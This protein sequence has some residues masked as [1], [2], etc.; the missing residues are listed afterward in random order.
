MARVSV[1]VEQIANKVKELFLQHIDNNDVKI[2]TGDNLTNFEVTRSLAAYAVYWKNG[3]SIAD[4]SGA[5]TD[6][7]GDNGIDAIYYNQNT[8]RLTI[9]QS[10]FIKDGNSEPEASEIR[11]FREGIFD[12]IEG[13]INSFNDKVKSK[14]EIINKIKEFGTKVDV[15]LVH[16]SRE[17]LADPSNEIIR[18]MMLDLN[19][20]DDEDGVFTFH[21]LH[22]KRIITSLTQALGGNEIKLEFLLKDYG[23]IKEPLLS[24]YGK[25][26]GSKLK[27]WWDLHSDRLFRDNIRNSLGNTSV[28][29]IVEKTI[30]DR[31]DYFWFFN[32]GITVIADLIDK[33]IENGNN[34]DFG[35]FKAENASIVNGAQTYSTIGKC[36]VKGVNIDK[37][38]VPFRVIQ[39][40][41]DVKELK[42]DIT[43]YN[44]TQ[45]TILPKDFLSQNDVQISLQEKLSLSGYKYVIKRDSTNINGENSFDF[46]EVTESLISTSNNPGSAA[47][48]RKEIG[49]F[50]NTESNLYKSV[51][52]NTIN[53]YRVINSVK[54]NRILKQNLSKV[55]ADLSRKEPLLAKVSSIANSGS[56]LIAQCL[57]K[58]LNSDLQVSL[59][60]A[61]CTIEY[62]EQEIE[63]T[64]RAIAAYICNNYSS[65][66]IVT[67]FQ[68]VDKVKEIFEKAS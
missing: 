30:E 26:N 6:G 48:Y 15:I 61:S 50:Y 9:V 10:K 43:R 41:K 66:Y 23:L 11:T 4:A 46:D 3:C 38:E 68:N 12:L 5:I 39:V 62:S 49:R 51:F 1:D 31:P 2:H 67:L 19:G 25:I 53:A 63:N 34:K 16:T 22:K 28:N 59:D 37:V 17:I 54:L 14:Q 13:N 58:K 47:I 55:A 44:N 45:N 7:Q 32:N 65:S 52:N 35:Y 40:N 56:I 60:Q 33:T 64:L 18:K 8:R 27:E 29:S 42:Q 21:I 57:Y 36:G 24:Y 20:S